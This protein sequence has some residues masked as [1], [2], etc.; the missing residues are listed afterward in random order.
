MRHE[1]KV[2]RHLAKQVPAGTLD[3]RP[4]QGRRS[5]REPL[6]YLSTAALVPAAMIPDGN[7][8]EG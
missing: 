1:V 7:G 4:A 5:T 3:W 8:E 2:I 6:R